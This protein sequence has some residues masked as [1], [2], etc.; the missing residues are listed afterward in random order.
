[1]KQELPAEQLHAILE[2]IEP[3][4]MPNKCNSLKASSYCV[5]G[6][7][8]LIEGRIP[9]AKRKLRETVVMANKNDLNKLTSCAFLLLGSIFLKID[10]IKDAIEMVRSAHDI[11]NRIPDCGLQLWST[12]LLQQLYLKTGEEDKREEIE[13]VH[14]GTV[15][16][17]SKEAESTQN[18]PEHGLLQ[19]LD[20]EFP[21]TS[22]SMV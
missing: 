12:D 4:K 7:A 10:N 16:K 21:T 15:D 2:S 13:K 8:A 14:Q 19:W 6:I 18:L 17:M 11:A 9:D 5:Q 3:S 20:S 1:M 22:M